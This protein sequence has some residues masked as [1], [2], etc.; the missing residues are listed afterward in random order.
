[1]TW[2]VERGDC[3]EVLERL[4]AESIDAV[5]T[6]P[7]YGLEFMGEDWDRPWAVGLRSYGHT[8]GAERVAGPQHGSSRNPVCRSCRKHKR[9]TDRC[10]CEAPDFDE[11]PVE[12]MR[13]YQAWCE[14][15]A[16]GCLR[17]LKPGGFLL[18]FG[19]TRTSHRLACAIEDAGFEIRDRVL[20]LNGNVLGAELEW[21][22]GS[23]WPKSHDVAKAIDRAAGAEREV[24][25]SKV[26]EPGYS[27]APDQGRTTYSET[28]RDPEVECAITAPATREAEQ[29]QGWG[30]ALKPA[31]EPIIVGRKP[32]R[33]TIVDQVLATGTGALNI[34]ATRIDT[35]GEQV[36]AGL[37]DPANR[38][39]LV[40]QAL[41]A[42][43]DAAKNQAAQRD[44]IERANRLGRWPANVVL[45]HAPDCE[46][47]GVRRVPSSVT[48]RRHLD[49]AQHEESI[50]RK[51]SHPGGVDVTYG[52]G[53]GL[54][55]VEAWDCAPGC[56]V[57]QLDELSG[58]DAGAA[59]P[60]TGN[61]P[62]LGKAVNTYKPHAAREP[63]AA[64][65][66]G[67]R[68]GASRFFYSGKA[69]SFERD[70]GLEGFEP[71]ASGKF[72]DDAYKWKYDGNGSE[73]REVKTQQRNPH[74]TVKPIDL[75]RWLVR[76]VTPPGGTVLDPFTGS[77]TTGCAATLEGFN[78][79]G[80]ERD[81]RFH[82]IAEARIRFWSR[83][84]AGTPTAAV[85]DELGV[86]RRRVQESEA[87]RDARGAA[88][89]LDL[90]AGGMEG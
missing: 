36:R 29:W 76:L 81:E 27:L 63:R 25:G 46:R 61:E 72:E 64:P 4:P 19:G 86:A 28:G 77:G 71:Q 12:A 31:H 13:A 57:A 14:R 69:S 43:G 45:L 90:L 54:E 59:A 35:G 73:R 24:I 85:L 60:V 74:P 84:P 47:V 30:T 68:G 6:D 32:F 39:G 56:P 70:A 22:Y 89:Q 66:Y 21:V 5:V 16:R 8:D 83:W 44:S 10:Q 65:F 18:A 40:G 53:D 3:L 55:T 2:R 51:R 26:G 52:D 80:V 88:G 15:W 1:M 62:S 87:L 42:V 75:M 9:G 67:D 78:F 48:V 79:L 41:Q 7:P 20:T 23:G 33:G 50:F 38:R 17:A 11:A 49:P 34:D 37:S 58:G 82:P